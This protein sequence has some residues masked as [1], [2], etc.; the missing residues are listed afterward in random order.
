MQSKTMFS[1]ASM[2]LREWMSNNRDVINSIPCGDRAETETA[3]ILGYTWNIESDCLSVNP[4]TV[5]KMDIKES[6]K[7][8]VLKQLGFSV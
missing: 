6:T 8:I 7:R 3:K 5:L 2:N 4:S 1:D